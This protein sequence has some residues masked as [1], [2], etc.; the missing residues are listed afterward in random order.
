MNIIS[1]GEEYIYLRNEEKI[2]SVGKSKTNIKNTYYL[3][4]NDL[5][6][7]PDASSSRNIFVVVTIIFRMKRIKFYLPFLLPS[8]TYYYYIVDSIDR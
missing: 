1:E 4:G 2:I 3:K 6:S 8:S 7:P 5:I